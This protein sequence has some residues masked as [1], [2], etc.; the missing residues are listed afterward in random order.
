MTMDRPDLGVQ[1]EIHSQLEEIMGKYAREIGWE[2]LPFYHDEPRWQ[3]RAGES[4]KK[5]VEVSLDFALPQLIRQFN[6]RY[7]LQVTASV[8]D[9]NKDEKQTAE[10]GGRVAR[11]PEKGAWEFLPFPTDYKP[12]LTP[13]EKEYFKRLSE[14]QGEQVP[15]PHDIIPIMQDSNSGALKIN[16][17][18]LKSSLEK[19]VNACNEY[20]SRVYEAPKQI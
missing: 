20:Y 15:L 9:E 5:N 7:V 16:Q 13:F 2:F 1:Y 12:E 19:A 4:D 10:V 18:R 8:Y 14:G 6:Q 11:V 3:L 17:N